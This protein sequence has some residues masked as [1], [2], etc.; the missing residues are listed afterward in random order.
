MRNDDI[1]LYNCLKCSDCNLACPGSS[2][3]PAFPG[4]KRLG[5]E[6]ERL[7]R[8]GI[9]CDTDRARVLSEL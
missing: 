7:R 9:H 8:E 5:P 4:P 6:L 3:D 2:S 1:S